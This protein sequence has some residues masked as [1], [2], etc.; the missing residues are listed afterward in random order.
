MHQLMLS[1]PLDSFDSLLSQ[2]SRCGVRKLPE[3]GG[4]Q[5][6]CSRYRLAFDSTSDP[7]HRFFDFGKLRHSSSHCRKKKTLAQYRTF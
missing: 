6:L 5:R 3:N 7:L 1:A 4:M 2:S